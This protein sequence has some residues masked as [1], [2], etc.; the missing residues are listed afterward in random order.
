MRRTAL[1]A[2]MLI[3]ACALAL[4]ACGS[5]KAGSASAGTS[6]AATNADAGQNNAHLTQ[7]Q[8]N[9]RF[10]TALAAI[11][12]VHVKG[13]MM[14]GSGT[15]Q[16]VTLDM[17]LNKNGTSQGTISRAGLDVPMIAVGST[18]YIQATGSYEQLLKLASVE[19]KN[20]AAS[21]AFF[22]QLTSGKW[23]EYPGA[24]AQQSGFGGFTDFFQ[25]TESLSDDNADKF[26]YIGTATLDGQQVAQYKDH[27]TDSSAPD[28]VM[29]IP[30][31]GNPLPIQEDAGKQGKMTFTWNQP[32]TITAPPAAQV[33]KVPA[34]LAGDLSGDSST[35]S[36]PT[37][38]A[39]QS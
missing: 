2:A 9:A 35:A 25:T 12:A 10:K 1:S 7:A 38:A 29:S 15:T 18:L 34:S 16:N 22:A 23:L 21:S 14:E 36:A 39:S 27:S 26:T 31:T 37:A 6:V 32:T 30:L 20:D 3:P 33:L 24:E 13:S 28:A 4:S 5:Q 19:L 8:L 11:T 17:Q